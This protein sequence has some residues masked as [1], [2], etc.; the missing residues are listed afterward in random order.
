MSAPTRSV[1]PYSVL[2]A[3]YHKAG[4]ADYSANLIP[5]LLELAFGL[6]WVGRTVL[7]LGCGTGEV[8]CWLAERSYRVIAVDN[9]QSMLDV[10][11][12]YASE[13]SLNVEWSCADIRTF[14]PGVTIDWA[15]ALGGTLNLLPTLQDLESAIQHVYAA[16][17]AGKLFIF[18]LD[19]IRGLS[20]EGD[21]DRIVYDDGETAL[22]AAQSRFSHET[23]TRTSAYRVFQFDGRAWE[24]ADETHIQRAFPVAAIVRALTRAGF[25]VLRTL[26]TDLNPA[27]PNDHNRLILVAQK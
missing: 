5:R 1:E 22:V 19:T 8:A 15:L 13:H 3:V 14:K 16:L 4:L 18:D 10:G 11:T 23:L 17:D 26:D 20:T 24:R 6:D 7:D 21:V 25:H 9:S 27:D 2:A 12:A